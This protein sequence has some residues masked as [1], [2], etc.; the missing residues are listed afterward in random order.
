MLK[1][2]GFNKS[3]SKH[4]GTEKYMMDDIKRRGRF[5][6]ETKGRETAAIIQKKK[7]ASFKAVVMGLKRSIKRALESKIN[8]TW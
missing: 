6:E 1:E 3:Q 8:M 5:E 4:I 7:Y 2:L